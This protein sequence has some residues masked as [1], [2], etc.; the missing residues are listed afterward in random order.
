MKLR[1]LTFLLPLIFAGCTIAPQYQTSWADKTLR[2]LTLREKIAQLMIY[3]MNMR[4][5]DIT[6]EKWDEI[7][8]H[9]STDGIGGIHLWYGDASSSITFINEMQHISKIPILF[10]A[11][12]EYGLH[13]RFPSGTDLPPLMAICATGEPQNAYDVGKIIAEESR[14][15]GV[16]WN[17]SPV[18]DVNNNP[19]NPI[20]NT[21]SFGEDPN[22]VGEFGV[23]LMKGLQDHGMLATAKHFPG[24]GDTE[25]D[26]HSSLAMIPNDSSRLWS[27]EIPPFKSMINAGVD[28]IMVAHVHAPDY[29]PNADTPASMD[30][31]WIQDVLRGRL[32]FN[33]T[34]ITDGMGM[35][36]IVKNYSDAF[37]LVETIKAGTDVVIQNYNI[38]GSIDTIERAVLDGEIS[39]ERINE[40]ALKMLRMKE[41]VGLHHQSEVSVQEIH[42]SLG[43]KKTRK[44]AK[45]IAS[46]AIT[47]VK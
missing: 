10:D 17:F 36:G 42:N 43:R 13:Q 2:K 1:N 39:I 38:K 33:G 35:G 8:V 40:A 26:S 23:Q 22:L 29:Q 27:V 41:K 12:L 34:V 45:R 25:T 18:V 6:P 7:L 24:H 21:R 15:V 46:E 37:A 28:A 5:K 19:A 16:Q 9:I 3:R 47:C 30:S 31:Y 11:D 44:T 14:A 20:I 4:F 32:N